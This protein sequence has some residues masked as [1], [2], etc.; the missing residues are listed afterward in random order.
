MNV[1]WILFFAGLMQKKKKTD[2][3]EGDNKK[4]DNGGGKGNVTVV[5]KADLHCD[6]CATKVIKCILS[7][8]GRNLC[9]FSLL[10][11]MHGKYSSIFMESE[12]NPRIAFPIPLTHN[13]LSDIYLFL[14]C[15]RPQNFLFFLPV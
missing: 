13:R 5:L 10:L 6:G 8:D 14:I 15:H 9:L 3:K 1:F 12:W 7:F 11:C 2:A 4:N